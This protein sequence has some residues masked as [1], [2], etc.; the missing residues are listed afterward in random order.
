MPLD[1]NIILGARPAQFDLSQF[2]PMN[3]M[4]NIMKLKQYDQESELNALKMQE[5]KRARDE[6][7]G[8]RNYL[9][10]G[11][12]MAAPD[13]SSSDTRTTLATRFGKTGATYAKALSEQDTAEL[14][15]KKTALEVQQAKQKFISQVQRDTSQNPSDANIT[16]YK[17][18]LIANPLFTDAEKAQMIAGADRI[19]A[20]PV[21]QRQAFMASQGA[22]AGELKPSNL[23]INRN[24]QTDVLR[25]PAFSGAPTTVGSFADV[26]LPANVQAQKIQ[27]AQ[28]SRPVTTVNLPPQEKAFETG[29]GKGQSERIL[30]NQVAAQDA[31][32][33]I[34]TV[35]T[36][37]DI[38]R[39]GMITGAGA[40]FLVNL[41]QGLKTVGIDAGLAD[42]AANSQAFTANMAGN[43]GKLIKQF[44]AGT[45]LSDA[46][47][48]FAKDM[49]G[50]RIALDAK[51][52]NR[53]LDI[54]EKAARN[55]IARHNKDVAGIK[56]NIP[57]TVEMPDA[58]PAAPS[59]AAPPT[60]A[61]AY[62]RANPTMKN[63]FDAKYGA[64]AADRALKGK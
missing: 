29:L 43:V 10:G 47:R 11:R 34:D 21:D 40:D 20:M 30:A 45:G 53:I 49:A 5:Y 27:I 38:M 22:T 9:S 46:D 17:E 18:D 6:E 52:I 3:A 50:G 26:P 54:N 31:A 1:P 39:S 42:A 19:L 33:I 55:T 12:E 13:L 64:G 4:T 58:T 61:I 51:A 14:T 63:A 62:L 23:Q 15:R 32:S 60:S 59:V 36:G 8:L 35:K 25:M 44:G 41:N 57:L 7:L 37:R 24:G 48:E 2:S 56:T 16:A 28:E